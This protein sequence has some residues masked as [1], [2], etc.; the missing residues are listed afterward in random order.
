MIG[1]LYIIPYVAYY[2]SSSYPLLFVLTGERTHICLE[3]VKEI[4]GLAEEVVYDR[5]AS[6]LLRECRER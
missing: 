1:A 6:P 2:T 5:N 3:V 4:E